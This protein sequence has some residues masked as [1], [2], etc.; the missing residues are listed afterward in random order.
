MT[1]F[2]DWLSSA[3]NTAKNVAGKV[4]NFIG[5]ADPIVGSFIGKAAHFVHNIG[6]FMNYLSGKLGTRGKTII[7]IAVR[8][9]SVTGMLPSRMREKGKQYTSR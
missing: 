5:K 6:H 4:C 2:S 3:C 1:R 8:V 7:R 9:D